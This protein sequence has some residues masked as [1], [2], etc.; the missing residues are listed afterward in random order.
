MPPLKTNC[1]IFN[2]FTEVLF[3]KISKISLNPHTSQSALRASFMFDSSL[4][5][6]SNFIEFHVQWHPYV[7]LQAEEVALLAVDRR[8]PLLATSTP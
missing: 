4:S 2:F 7:L 6:R 3:E 5:S 1:F 8:Q